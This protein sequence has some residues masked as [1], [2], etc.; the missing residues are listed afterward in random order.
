MT[1]LVNIA[2]P[3]GFFFDSDFIPFCNWKY[4]YFFPANKSLRD[5]SF[6]NLMITTSITGYI[7]IFTLT[8]GKNNG[9]IIY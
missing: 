2:N 7:E 1:P 3:G 9:N 8:W 4:M 5:I 6:Y